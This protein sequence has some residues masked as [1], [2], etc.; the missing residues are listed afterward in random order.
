MVAVDDLV[1]VQRTHR[2]GELV[3]VRSDGGLGQVRRGTGVEVADPHS[4]AQVHDIGLTRVAAAGDEVDLVAQL[5]KRLGGVT[6]DD[7]HPAGITRSGGIKG[8]RVHR[9]HGDTQRTC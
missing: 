8:R 9:H 1:R 6:L 2:G 3:D 5:G 7:V 4:P